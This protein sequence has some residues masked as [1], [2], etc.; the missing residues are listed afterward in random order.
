[1]DV[2]ID[3]CVGQTL[4]RQVSFTDA[5]TD[6]PWT[7]TVDY[8]DGSPLQTWNLGT[9]QTF[10]L[11]HSYAVEALYQVTVTVK[12]SYGKSAAGSFLVI[13]DAPPPTAYGQLFTVNDGNG[14]RSMVNSL[15]V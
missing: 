11:Q 12:D 10:I 1:P 2:S 9:V 13:D 15:T 3:S 14:Q 6:G 8:G 7:A 5:A 4:T